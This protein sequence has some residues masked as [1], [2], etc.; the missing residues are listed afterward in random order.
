[1][2]V[3]LMYS[4]HAPS[5]A[6]LARLADL[7]AD[8][9]VVD[10]EAAAIAAIPEAHVVIGH[11]YLRQVLPFAT[12]LRWVQSTAGGVDRLP[13]NALRERGI[14]LTRFSRAAPTIARHAVTL[15]WSV[16]RRIPEAV[17]N[18]AAAR[19]EPSL[20]WLPLPRRALVLGAGAIGQAIG[21]LLQHDGIE[22]SGV[23]R[24]PATALPG[25]DN[26]LGE[27]A[28]RDV[29]PHTD[30]LFLALPS[31]P[32]TFHL[33]GEEELQQLPSHALV[34]NVGRGETLDTQ[35]LCRTLGSG[36]LGGA[37]LDVVEPEFKQADSVLWRTPRLLITP[38]V[39]AHSAERT[40]S[41]EQF[42][43]DQYRRFVSGEALHDRVT[44]ASGVSQ[45]R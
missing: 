41:I 34:V 11:R 19:W 9:T 42:V 8:V 38:H 3:L 37:A 35:A 29:L 40:A 44:P 32:D 18:Q 2:R 28:W 33:V 5:D 14:T 27:D 1:M 43:E 13:L 22:T 24:T 17:R 26:V 4:T 12:D 31:T 25:F 6:H 36:L 7:G 23:R 30:W 39:A 45:P 10:S 15:A 21:M 16:T 20:D